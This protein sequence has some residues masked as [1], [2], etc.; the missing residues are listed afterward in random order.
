MACA[1][2][3]GLIGFEP[4]E[5]MRTTPLHLSDLTLCCVDNQYP[6]L[7]FEAIQ[8]T[9][10]ELSFAEVLFFTHPDFVLPSHEIKNLTVI[11]SEVIRNIEDYSQFMLKG[12]RTYVKSSHVLT[13]QWDGFVIRPQAWQHQFLQYDYIGAP[14]P[15]KTG[16]WVGNGGFSLRSVKLLIALQDEAIKPTHPE[17][18][19]ICDQ[20][21]S[22]LE[23]VHH[24]QFAP[25][26][27]ADAFSFEFGK[28]HPH[29]F[30][31]HGMSNFPIVMSDSEL[32]Y[33]IETMPDAL[34]FNGYFRLFV[35]NAVKLKSDETRL[36]LEKKVTAAMMSWGV[37]RVTSD[38]M[39]DLIKT[40]VKARCLQLAWQLLRSRVTHQGWRKGNVQLAARVFLAFFFLK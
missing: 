13:I 24:I 35:L 38:A 15:K 8:K 17:D 34:I 37:S 28:P 2:L 29:A 18:A 30:G 1:R 16:P 19:C 33:F 22:Y 40:F 20:Y 9:C 5:R 21:R 3:A 23:D 14:W 4:K 31:F 25:P 7:G 26:E 12:L 36:A 27:L 11:T 6:A 10:A 39:H 32:M